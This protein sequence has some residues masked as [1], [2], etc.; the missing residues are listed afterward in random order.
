MPIE[1]LSAACPSSMMFF[2]WVSAERV[3]FSVTVVLSR[4]SFSI[5]PFLLD[6]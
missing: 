3:L 5:N 1:N 2:S 4:S 6:I